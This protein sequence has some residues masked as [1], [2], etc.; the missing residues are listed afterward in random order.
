MKETRTCV[1]CSKPY[2]REASMTFDQGQCNGCIEAWAKERAV[3]HVDKA[4]TDG[5][6]PAVL[7]EAL[8]VHS[9]WNK[10]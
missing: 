5:A 6:R 3:Q 2:E 1:V 7:R 10:P 4:I 8:R 9:I